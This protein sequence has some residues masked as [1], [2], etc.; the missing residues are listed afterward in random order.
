MGKPEYGL[1]VPAAG[2]RHDVRPASAI[3][4]EAT[5]DFISTHYEGGGSSNVQTI[6]ERINQAASR[7]VTRYPTS[8]QRAWDRA[9]LVEVGTV[10]YDEDLRHWVLAD[11]LDG[12]TLKRWI[13]DEPLPPVGGSEALYERAAGLAY[14]RLSPSDHA[15]LSIHRHDRMALAREILRLTAGRRRQP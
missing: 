3:V 10:R 4:G 5:G 6:E 9:D 7:R 14:S 13:G 12:E 2:V 11:I 1:Y 8:A 15:R